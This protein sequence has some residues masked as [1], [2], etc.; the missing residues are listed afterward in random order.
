MRFRDFAAAL[1]TAGCLSDKQRSRHCIASGSPF[2]ERLL[3]ASAAAHFTSNSSSCPEFQ[4]LKKLEMH[5]RCVRC[6]LPSSSAWD[7]NAYWLKNVQKDSRICSCT[8]EQ[9][10]QY[11]S[12]ELK[13][14]R[15]WG[16]VLMVNYRQMGFHYDNPTSNVN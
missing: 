5:L 2:C 3:R 11:I 13:Y 16:C 8:S 4:Q 14:P 10:Q 6:V 12:L 9:K 1:R 7:A 15:L